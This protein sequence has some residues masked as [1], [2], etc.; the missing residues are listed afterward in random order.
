MPFSKDF[1]RPFLSMADSAHVAHQS[2]F[3]TDIRPMLGKV[4]PTVDNIMVAV[5]TTTGPAKD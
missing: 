4:E 3:D 5:A 2:I 1:Y